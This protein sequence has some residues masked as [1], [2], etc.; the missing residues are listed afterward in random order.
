MIGVTEDI[1]W[2]SQPLTY[3]AAAQSAKPDKDALEAAYQFCTVVGYRSKPGEL[4]KLTRM[5]TVE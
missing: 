4:N 2:L 1:F 5:T 3:L